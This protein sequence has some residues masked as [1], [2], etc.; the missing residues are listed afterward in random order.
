MVGTIGD[1]SA[2]SRRLFPI[3]LMGIDKPG[4]Q[5]Q[6]AIKTPHPLGISASQVVVDGNY[7]SAAS[8]QGVQVS[9]EGGNQG[10]TFPG[11]HLGNLVEVQGGTAHELHI[12]MAHVEHAAAGFT[13]NRKGFRQNVLHHLSQGSVFHG[14][15]LPGH[16]RH[17][18]GNQLDFRHIFQSII[19]S[20]LEL[21]SFAFQFIIRELTHG[22][23]EGISLVDVR[24][25]SLDPLLIGIA[26]HLLDEVFGFV[27]PITHALF[28]SS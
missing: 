3:G 9:R 18:I 23:G 21:G 28:L 1:I 10:L 13:T 27:L 2:V 6:E 26:K 19:N 20:L 4:G 25:Q 5:A 11:T 24:L 8:G 22:I 12:E 15:N 7:V 14:A 17:I 16:L